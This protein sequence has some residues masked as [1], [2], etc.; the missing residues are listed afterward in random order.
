MIGLV[1]IYFIGKAYYDLAELHH[2]SKW[3]FAILGVVSYYLGVVIGGVILGVLSELQVIAIDDIPEIVVGLMAL[4]MGILSCWGF[5][6][7]LQKQ[8]SKT[9]VPETT[10]VLDGDLIK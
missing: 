1:F 4:P 5:Y 8:W 10:D 2:K 6:K 3:G 9:A 7:L